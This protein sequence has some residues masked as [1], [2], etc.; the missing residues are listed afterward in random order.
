MTGIPPARDAGFS[1]IE[2]L[3]S[4]FVFAVIGTISV[5]LMASSVSARDINRDVLART[6]MLDRTRTLLRE[7]IG[8]IARRPVRDA[9]GYR[10]PFIFA[11]AS[12]GL[13]D[14][15]AD[16][17]ERVLMSFT[18]YGRDNP[19]L[20][21]S[22]SSLVHV[23]YV[24]RN[25]TLVRRVR[26]Y[27]DPGETTRITDLIMLEGVEDLR[28]DFLVGAAWQNRAALAADGQGALPSAIRLSYDME[29]LGALEH[30]VL[31]PEAQP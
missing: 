5:A 6:E 24:S 20:L 16:R 13:A 19:G 25:A 9:A 2:I 7:D 30:I 4:V 1:L 23:T 3:V 8:Q 18:R 29:P 11:G 10:E 17:N 27:P 15:E 12:T 31:T 28:V 26:D 22:R 21:R 14:P